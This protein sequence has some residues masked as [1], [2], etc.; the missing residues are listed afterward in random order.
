MR[1]FEGSWPRKRLLGHLFWFGSWL[2]V[3]GVGFALRPDPQ[4]HG[5]H[6]QLGLPPCPSIT[7]AGRP[8]PGCGLTT[9]FTAL[10]KGNWAAAF[11][12]HALGPILYVLF[13]LTAFACLYGY[14]KQQRFVTDSRTFNRAMT[15][16]LLVFVGYGVA[17]F[18]ITEPNEPSFQVS[19][20]ACG[21]Q[22]V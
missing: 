22:S 15:A 12:A 6:T 1:F 10:L 20:P 16:L 5:T 18:F 21:A 13:T 3:T 4:G 19:C 9:S 2:G 8:C 7:V 17:R 14:L 11:Q